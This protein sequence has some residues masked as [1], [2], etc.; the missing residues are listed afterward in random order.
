M[1]KKQLEY[2]ATLNKLGRFIKDADEL[3]RT[4]DILL[5]YYEP[6]RDQFFM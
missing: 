2:D 1:C 3:K 4:Y 5:K 6:L